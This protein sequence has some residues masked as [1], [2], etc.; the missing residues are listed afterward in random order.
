MC[1]ARYFAIEGWPGTARVE[2]QLWQQADSLLPNHKFAE[3]T[4][5]M[6][7]L[8]ATLCTRSNPNCSGCPVQTNCQAYAQQRQAELPTPKPSKK[9]PQ[10]EVVVAIIQNSQDGSIWLEKRPPT[11][12]WGGLYSFPE[13]KDADVCSRFGS[14][15]TLANIIKKPQHHHASLPVI[16]HTFSHFRLHMHPIAHSDQ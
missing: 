2:Q 8:G 7:D 10:R 11:G 5:A 4:Q 6:M 9:I 13:F 14:I 15:S 16:T 3:Y 12:I 1:L